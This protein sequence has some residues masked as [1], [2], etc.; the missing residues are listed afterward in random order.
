MGGAAGVSWTMCSVSLFL[1]DSLLCLS[2]Q[3][4]S[5]RGMWGRGFWNWRLALGRPGFAFN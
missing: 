4:G 1:G 2:L 3:P 5:S